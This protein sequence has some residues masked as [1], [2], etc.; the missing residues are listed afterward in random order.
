LGQWCGG[1]RIGPGPHAE[2]LGEPPGGDRADAVEQPQRAAPR[3]LVPRVVEQ[4]EESEQVL[5]VGRLE[6]SQPAVLDVRDVAPRQLQLEEVG[7]PRGAEQH[8]LAAQGD[9][10][11]AVGQHAVAHG[12]RLGCLVAARA[13]DGPAGT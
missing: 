10:V 9:V 6:E 4:A 1:T 5:D 3:Q 11:V 7:M 8:G 13:Q 2:G 12:R